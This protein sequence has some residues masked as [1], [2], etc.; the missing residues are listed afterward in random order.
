M[1]DN[2]DIELQENPG[3]L[4]YTWAKD[5]FPLN[6]SLTGEGVRE[7]LNYLKEIIPELKI[8]AVKS[9]TRAFDWEI[10]QEWQITDAYVADLAGNRLIDFKK[11][12]LHVVG[13]SIPINRILSRQELEPHLFSLKQQPFAIPY[14]TS[15]YQRNW[16]FCIS[17]NQR[18]KLGEGPFRVLIDSKH[19]N[20]HMN[21]GELIIPG[22]I[23]KEILL[24]TN[25]C[26]PS[27]ANNELS[28]PIILAALSRF[29]T[30]KLSNRLTYRIL[31]LPETIGSIYY[32]SRNL[33]RLKKNVVAGWTLTCLG[34]DS[35]FSYLPSRSGETLADRVS[36]LALNE[37]DSFRTYSWLDRGSDERQFCSPGIDLPIASIMR[38]KYGAYPEYHTS[39]DNLDFISEAGLRKSFDLFKKL[40]SIL[41]KND[42][43]KINVKCEPQLSKRLMYPSISIKAQD[44]NQINLRN[45]MN[46]ISYLDGRHDLIKIAEKC[47]LSWS[48]IDSIVDELK[49]QKLIHKV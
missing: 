5:L 45:K 2:L 11:N 10:P 6:R 47:N 16:G 4:M 44:G 36:K 12:N 17:H 19:F 9:G 21:Y 49:I 14:V 15:Y 39:L 18:L 32:L 35:E 7:T 13:Y 24:S 37:L 1:F 38:S 40:V 34:D 8:K 48:K 26:H 31:F 33:K 23:K 28:G 25:I 20:G 41:E 42:V 29:I 22:K 27:L 30:T 46:V 3:K 43:Y